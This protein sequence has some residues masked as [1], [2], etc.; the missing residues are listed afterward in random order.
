MLV[1]TAQPVLWLSWQM[2]LIMVPN[3]DVPAIVQLSLLGAISADVE[4]MRNAAYV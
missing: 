3:S 4:C 1:S 2:G